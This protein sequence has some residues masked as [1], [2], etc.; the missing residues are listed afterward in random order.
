MHPQDDILASLESQENKPEV[1]FS[2]KK[3]DFIPNEVFT[4]NDIFI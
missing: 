1:L 4:Q 3:D 2:E